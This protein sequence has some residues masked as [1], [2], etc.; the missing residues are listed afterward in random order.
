MLVQVSSQ[1][2]YF[3]WTIWSLLGVRVGGLAP[4]SPP[5]PKS[6]CFNYLTGI[7]GKVYQYS[8]NLPTV[9]PDKRT[10]PPSYSLNT[11][12]LSPVFSFPIHIGVP[13]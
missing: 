2:F 7:C 9:E 6:C 8:I 13:R 4:L 12:P 1:D 10:V 5:F 3:I 11:F